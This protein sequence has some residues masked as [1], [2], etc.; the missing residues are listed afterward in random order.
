MRDE[1]VKSPGNAAAAG[2]AASAAGNHSLS[3]AVNAE[4]NNM[5]GKQ[6]SANKEEMRTS[7]AAAA[8]NDCVSDRTSDP[9]MSEAS[10]SSF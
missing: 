3:P 2:A 5:V 1:A 6:N 7:D 4:M 9:S 10:V 8:R